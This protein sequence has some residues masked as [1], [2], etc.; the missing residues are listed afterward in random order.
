MTS[1]SPEN[2][3]PL[4]GSGNVM[5]SRAEHAAYDAV[6]GFIIGGAIGFGVS[7]NEIQELPVNLMCGGA[8]GIALGALTGIT[9]FVLRNK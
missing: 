6:L 5:E 7:R 9:S 8:A 3:Q 1:S 2:E 4:S